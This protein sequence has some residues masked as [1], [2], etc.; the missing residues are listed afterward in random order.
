MNLSD[1]IALVAKDTRE[2][3]DDSM[4]D[5]DAIDCARGDVTVEHLDVVDNATLR[6]AY[7]IVLAASADDVARAL[8]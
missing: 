5:R 4:T 8:R 6:E 7:E 3:T 2:T 1:A